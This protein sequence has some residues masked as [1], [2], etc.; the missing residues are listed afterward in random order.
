MRFLFALTL[1]SLV[2]FES[3]DVASPGR[4]TS[5]QGVRSDRE[6]G[7]YCEVAGVR[8]DPLTSDALAC[9][10]GSPSR[11]FENGAPAVAD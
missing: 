3:I 5:G 7:A 2:L 6:R 1:T 8:Q 10:V 11:A 4:A 9:R